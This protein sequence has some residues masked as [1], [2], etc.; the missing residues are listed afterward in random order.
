MKP[1][2]K[3]GLTTEEASRVLGVSIRTVIRYFDKGILMGWRNPVTRY[4]VV[5]P[6]SVKALVVL[7]WK[8]AVT[9]RQAIDEF[10]GREHR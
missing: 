6:E 5:D 4:R 7:K 10:A 3:R 2:R 8:R 1:K 9:I